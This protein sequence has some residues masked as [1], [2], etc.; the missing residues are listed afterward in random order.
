MNWTDFMLGVSATLIVEAIAGIVLVSWF[1]HQ[2][3][4]FATRHPTK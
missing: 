1:R 2:Q 3:E 4:R